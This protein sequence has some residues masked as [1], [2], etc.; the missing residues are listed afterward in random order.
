[1]SYLENAL[2]DPLV[3]LLLLLLLYN[4]AKKDSEKERE[5]SKKTVRP[6]TIP[7]LKLQAFVFHILKEYAWYS[8]TVGSINNQSINTPKFKAHRYL[9]FCCL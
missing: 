8:N 7:V 4:H 6:K 1:M 9:K 3:K 5:A 2:R